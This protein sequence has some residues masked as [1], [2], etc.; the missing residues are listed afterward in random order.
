MHDALVEVEHGAGEGRPDVL[1]GDLAGALGV[2]EGLHGLQLVGRRRAGDASAEDEGDA[3]GVIGGRG[4]GLRSEGAGRF[5]EHLVVEQGEGLERA[6]GHVAAGDAGFAGGRVEGRGHRERGGAL[7]EGVER[8]TVAVLA[9]AGLPVDLTI[10]ALT[11]DTGGL[12]RIDAGSAHLEGDQAGRLQRAV[13]DDF[14]VEAEAAA[15]GEQQVLAILLGEL[16]CDARGLT[17]GAAGDDE[18][19][20]LFHRPAGALEFDGEPVEQLRVRRRF[21]L[22]AEVFER[23]DEATAEKGLPLAVHGH[24]GGQR[25]LRREEP[26]REGQA[27]GGGVFGQ[28]GQEGGH[29]GLHFFARVQVLAA[30]VTYGRSRVGGGALA[31]DE[32]GLAARDALAQ[33]GEGLGMHGDFGRGLEEAH[34][35]GV[36]IL[37]GGAGEH[38]LDRRGVA[39]GGGLFVGGDGEAEVAERAG[40][41]LFEKHLQ[42]PAGREVGRLGETEDGRLALT[43]AAQHL[44]AA[45]HLAIERGGGIVL[46]AGGLAFRFGFGLG[47][48]GGITDTIFL[49]V[50]RRDGFTEL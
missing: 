48:G 35:Q 16:R 29:A 45:R 23:G 14:G 26:A 22:V 30:V 18:A 32:R 39:G 47:R 12:G 3:T 11:G 34:A 15:P 9:F 2:D 24:T 42:G 43:V 37:R 36:P 25:I 7:D 20:E 6:V 19:V 33:G 31:H 50:V 38:G 46:L 17:V 41:V 49:F 5:H 28:A 27:V 40:E 4:H 1:V 13:A 21:A 10:G 44:P 8:T